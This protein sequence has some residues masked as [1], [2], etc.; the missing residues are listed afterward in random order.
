[1]Y[2]IFSSLLLVYCTVEM[3]RESNQKKTDGLVYFISLRILYYPDWNGGNSR[4][5]HQ[6][7]HLVLIH[8][9][10]G[11][12]IIWREGRG[13]DSGGSSSILFPDNLIFSFYHTFLFRKLHSWVTWSFSSG[14]CLLKKKDLSSLLPR[15]RR[16]LERERNRF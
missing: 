14:G 16:S 2:T 6:T 12:Y 3:G 9:K 11:K 4:T 10:E 7:K 5:K 15:I 1:M 8:Q 13:V